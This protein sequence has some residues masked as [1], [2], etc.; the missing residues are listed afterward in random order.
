MVMEKPS[1]LLVGREFVRQYYTLLNKAPDFLHRFYG[2]NSSYVHG[3]LDAN[4]KLSEAVY[5]QAEIHQKVLSLQFSECHT[6]IRHVDAHASLSDAVVVQVMGELSNNG[7]PMRRFLQTFV[8]APEGSV[9]N[10]FYVH[11]DIFRYEDEVFGDSEAEL[12]E[13]YNWRGFLFQYGTVD[14]NNGVEEAHEEAALELEPEAAEEPKIEEPKLKAE[15]KMVEEFEEKAPSPDPMESPPNIQEPPKTSSWASVTSKNLPLAGTVPSSGA[16]PH[17]IKAPNSQP[18]VEAKSELSSASIRPRDQRIRDRPSVTSRGPRSDG[19]SSSD[20]QTG[21][22]HFSFVNK[23][24][25]DDSG[26][27]DGRR[28]LRYPDSHQLFVGNLPHDI[29]ESEL[30]DFFMSFGNVVELRINTKGTGGKIPNFGFVVFDD[31]EPVQRILG[32]KP[33]MFRGEVRLNVE[34]KKTRAMRERETRSGAEDRRDARRGDRALGGP[35]GFMM[36]EREARG[37]P[38]RAV[39]PGR[40]TGSS[41]GRFTAPR[42]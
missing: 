16:Q 10:K 8:L 37:P 18:R 2:R 38:S 40:S 22:P 39:A 23:G 31:S 26:E 19:V 9:A 27:V 41:E 21:K 24:R 35:R 30:K 33:I 36:R 11:N 15:E 3:G 6:K 12:D 7:Q 5:G 34:E 17:V 20:S 32:V 13:D 29:D 42:R 4:G 28:V 25:A 1:P 14:C